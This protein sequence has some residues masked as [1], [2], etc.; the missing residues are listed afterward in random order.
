MSS[1]LVLC[2]L[3]SFLSPL[4]LQITPIL[5]KVKASLILSVREQSRI[6]QLRSGICLCP[7]SDSDGVGTLIIDNAWRKGES[8]LR[9]DLG[10]EFAV[11]RVEE[12]LAMS[13]I[14]GSQMDTYI[15]S[16]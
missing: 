5:A 12:R 8:C 14:R 11:C 16:H 6:T 1:I 7:Q 9:S 10:N 15:G 4:W 13:G 3:Q 2:I